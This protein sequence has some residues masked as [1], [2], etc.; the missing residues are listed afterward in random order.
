MQ[1]STSVVTGLLNKSNDYAISMVGHEVFLKVVDYF[2]SE[3]CGPFQVNDSAH[4]RRP[5]INI[6]Y[7]SLQVWVPP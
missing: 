4:T 2:L 6:F 3:Q 1:R 7:R 5:R